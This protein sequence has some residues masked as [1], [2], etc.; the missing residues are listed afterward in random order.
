MYTDEAPPPAATTAGP[1]PLLAGLVAP[2]TEAAV[3]QGGVPSQVIPPGLPP[4][5]NASLQGQQPIS[6]GRRLVL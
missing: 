3:V 6:G 2:P 1:S 4:R 5:L